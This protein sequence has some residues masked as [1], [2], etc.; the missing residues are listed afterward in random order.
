MNA[1]DLVRQAVDDARQINRSI[2]HN[3]KD[4]ARLLKGNL[5]AVTRDDDYYSHELIVA[6][7]KELTQYNANTRTWKN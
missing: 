1:F 7:K 6:L 5:R 3:A 4:L 2:E